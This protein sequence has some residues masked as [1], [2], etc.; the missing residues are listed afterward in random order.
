MATI[1]ELIVPF[2]KNC[3]LKAKINVML[4]RKILTKRYRYKKRYSSNMVL[5][6]ENDINF[7]IAF[8]TTMLKVLDV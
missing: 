4:D 2:Y 7:L 5:K 8:L 6:H 3:H 1:Y